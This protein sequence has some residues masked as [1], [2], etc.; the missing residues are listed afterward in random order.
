[1]S[2][3]RNF[4]LVSVFAIGTVQSGMAESIL[5][6]DEEFTIVGAP[7]GTSVLSARWGIW[8]GSTFVQS[9][10]S[11]LNSGSVDMS[12]APSYYELLA[13]LNQTSNTIFAQGTHLA[14]AIFTDGSVNAQNLNWGAQPPAYAVVLVDPSWTAPAFTN[15]AAF[16][17]FNF[18]VNT[19]ATFG[20][21]SFNEGDKVITLAAIPEPSAL[22]RRWACWYR[23]LRICSYASSPWRRLIG[24]RAIYFGQSTF[25]FSPFSPVQFLG[26]LFLFRAGN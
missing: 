18:S 6:Y 1:M 24:L 23:D 20:G 7:G 16:V 4:A 22:R 13:T 2:L 3:L 8:N 26:G 12:S 21:F 17:P 14:L 5:I 25:S 15:S 19:T 9:V 11:G 10:T